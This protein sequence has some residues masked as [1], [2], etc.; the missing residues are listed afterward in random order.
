MTPGLPADPGLKAGPCWSPA[1]RGL[2][3]AICWSTC[4]REAQRQRAGRDRIRPRDLAKLAR[5]QR[6]DLL[7]RDTVRAALRELRPAVVY[8]CAGV[9]HVAQSWK[10]SAHAL[11]GNVIGTHVLL[12]ELRRI[13]QPVR[14]LVTGSATVYAA[15]DQPIGEDGRLAPASPT[16]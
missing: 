2:P 12:D 4:P 15:T 3:A 10:A 11:E 16:R 9:P 1:R 6:V 7:A 14:L 13:G 5:W 8:H